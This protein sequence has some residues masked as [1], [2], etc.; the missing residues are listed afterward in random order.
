MTDI[1]YNSVAWFEIGT[2]KADE[3]RRFYGELFDWTFNITE[4]GTLKYDEVTTPGADRPSGGIMESDGHFP[5]YAIFYVVVRDVTETVSQ[6]EAL[7]GKVIVPAT[8]TEAGL[9]FAQL[10][11][12]AGHH[13]GVFSPPAP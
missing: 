10:Q 5:D 2:G 11:D 1:A 8:T 13:F 7:G 12:S 9:T 4:G 3:T 6:A